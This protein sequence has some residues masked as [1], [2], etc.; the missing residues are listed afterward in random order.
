MPRRSGA[1]CLVG[2]LTYFRELFAETGRLSRWKHPVET[3]PQ[4]NDPARRFTFLFERS[5]SILNVILDV[6]AICRCR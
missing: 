1:F 6:R 2:R 4:K 3:A 5:Y